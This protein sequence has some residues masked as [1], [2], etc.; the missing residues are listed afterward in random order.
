MEPIRRFREE[1]D[2]DSVLVC[3]PQMYSMTAVA[4]GRASCYEGCLDV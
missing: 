4:S 1:F 2:G 3:V